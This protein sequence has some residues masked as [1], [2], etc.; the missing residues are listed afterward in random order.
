MYYAK[1]I[2][3]RQKI[4]YL[5]EKWGYDYSTLFNDETRDEFSTYFSQPDY[6]G[7]SNNYGT[8]Y[9][10]PEPIHIPKPP[11]GSAPYPH[12]NNKYIPPSVAGRTN[13]TDGFAG[14]PDRRQPIKYPGYNLAPA[15]NHIG[16]HNGHR[17]HAHHSHFVPSA[18]PAGYNSGGYSNQGSTYFDPN[19]WWRYVYCNFL[20]YLLRI[21]T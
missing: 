18:G 19:Y 15:G 10:Y 4:R 5:I 13:Y 21:Y 16:N 8:G 2:Y 9:T 12:P 1:M 11:P 17:A 14:Y 6:H 7:Y 3:F 20:H